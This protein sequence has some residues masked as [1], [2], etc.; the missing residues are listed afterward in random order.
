[1]VPGNLRCDRTR[2][3]SITAAVP[4]P[5][6]FAPGASLVAFITSVT[7][8]SMWP[9]MTTTSFGRSV[10]RWIA[11][12]L[13][14]LVGVGTRRPVTVS[15]VRIVS[16]PVFFSSASVQARAAPMPRFGSVC[17]DRVWRVPKL[18]SF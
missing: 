14:T 17:D 4:L 15:Q 16:S 1:M 18:T 11:T 10:P 5:S 2:A 9:V 7:R 8:L 12:T 6:S 13:Q 3:A